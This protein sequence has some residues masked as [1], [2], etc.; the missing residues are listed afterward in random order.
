VDFYISRKLGIKQTA[1]WSNFV[2]APGAKSTEEIISKTDRGVFLTRYSG[3]SPGDNLDF[4]GI[5][6]NAFYIEAGQVRYPL[7]ETMISSN[8]R[9]LILAIRDISKDTVNFGTAEYPTIAAGGVTI[10]AH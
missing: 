9:D 3:G 4:S 10:H 2:V 7:A 6:K 1:G 8:L 5:A